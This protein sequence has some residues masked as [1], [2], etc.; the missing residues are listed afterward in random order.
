M[1]KAGGATERDLHTGR[2]AYLHL[3]GDSMDLVRAY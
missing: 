1:T 2:L 3:A